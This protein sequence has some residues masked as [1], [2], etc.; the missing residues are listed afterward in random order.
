VL[1]LA[2]ELVLVLVLVLGLRLLRL[3]RAPLR[4][5]LPG[6][7]QRASRRLRLPG[8]PGQAGADQAR[9]RSRSALP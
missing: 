7:L 1:R 9:A 6:P 8:R 3:V 4:E 5:L 2:L